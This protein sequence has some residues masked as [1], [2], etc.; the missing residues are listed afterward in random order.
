MGKRASG[1]E[2]GQGGCFDGSEEPFR[3]SSGAKAMEKSAGGCME[4]RNVR[5]DAKKTD[6]L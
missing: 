3:I 2:R 4:I 1:S 6:E 5:A